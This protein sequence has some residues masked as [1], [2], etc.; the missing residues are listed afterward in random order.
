MAGPERVP[1]LEGIVSR[2]QLPDRQ[3]EPRPVGEA[4]GNRAE[5]GAGVLMT[6][7]LSAQEL[8]RVRLAFGT[9]GW[10]KLPSLLDPE[11]AAGLADA[12]QRLST[13]DDEAWGA[14]LTEIQER[15][16]LRNL[17]G[18]DDAFLPLLESAPAL[19]FVD[20]LLGPGAIL[21][22]FDALTLFP[23]RGRYPW[24]FHT[25]LMD[26]RGVAFPSG[27][28]PGVTV[29]Y[30][31]D[32]VRQENGATWVVPGSQHSPLREP[33][34]DVLADMA[35]PMEVEPGDA[36]IL[37]PRIWHCAGTNSTGSPRTLIKTT[38]TRSWYR[39]QMDFTRAVPA[40]MQAKMSPR[41]LAYLAVGAEPPVTVTELRRRL[42]GRADLPELQTEAT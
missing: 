32:A 10:V 38:F 5:R 23:G 18:E 8:E 28:R 7:T 25:D 22:C 34:V 16:A 11:A 13:A 27:L 29:L 2:G 15:G 12:L 19:D 9:A 4:V 1:A 41:G 42:S 21:N 26:L 31:F 37:D 40:Q 6:S 3:D 14:R 24:D 39:P 36:V 30:Y 17:A 33:S 35:I 20:H